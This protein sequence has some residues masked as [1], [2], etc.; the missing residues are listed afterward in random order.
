MEVFVYGYRNHKVV[1]NW[2][3]NSV[4]QVESIQLWSLGGDVIFLRP[5]PASVRIY[6]ADLV[7]VVWL[8][9][10]STFKA[11]GTVERPPTRVKASPA[12]LR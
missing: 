6:A 2:K 4:S 10:P 3:N 5:V 8:F 11:S 1:R 7:S 12:A 9:F